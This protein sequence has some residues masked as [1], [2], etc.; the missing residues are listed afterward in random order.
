MKKKI[1]EAETHNAQY[2]KWQKEYMETRSNKALGEMYKI[3]REIEKNYIN[4]YCRSHGVIFDD[5]TLEEK[6]E[7]ATMFIIE[8]YMRKPDFHIDKISAYAHFGMIKALFK[9]MD[10]E[11]NEISWESYIASG[12]RKDNTDPAEWTE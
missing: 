12:E 2:E 11:K 9:D 8:Q 10:R 7:I 1:E 3:V 4:K 6:I 5:D